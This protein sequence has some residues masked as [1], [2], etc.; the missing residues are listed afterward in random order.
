MLH[1]I[2]TPHLVKITS[3]KMLR[4]LETMLNKGKCHQMDCSLTLF[5]TLPAASQQKMHLGENVLCEI[6]HCYAQKQGSFPTAIEFLLLS[7][8]RLGAS[9]PPLPEM[10]GSKADALPD[11]GL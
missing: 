8:L 9:I 5:S 6:S 3:Q 7:S 11:L 4:T 2:V 1:V 10:A